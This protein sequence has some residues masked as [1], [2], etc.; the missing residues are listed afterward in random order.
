VENRVGTM[1]LIAGSWRGDGGF[2]ALVAVV[3]TIVGCAE[4]PYLGRFN[5]SA[6][7][8]GN[9]ISIAAGGTFPPDQS[10]TGRA[11]LARRDG[12]GWQV[13]DLGE[14][15]GLTGIAFNGRRWVAVGGEFGNERWGDGSIRE[16]GTVVIS[17]D[18]VTWRE[19][20]TAPPENLLNVVTDGSRFVATAFGSEYVYYSDDGDLWRRIYVGNRLGSEARYA[21]GRFM[22]YGNGPSIME[23]LDGETW[24]E[25]YVG[26]A[27]V[28][29]IR[30]HGNLARGFGASCVQCDPESVQ[31]RALT[32][33]ESG[34]W[35]V[36]A[37][38]GLSSPYDVVFPEGTAVA[39]TF[40]G[41]MFAVDDADGRQWEPIGVFDSSWDSLH[42][43]GSDV[44]LLGFGI[45]VSRDGGR[46]WAL[47]VTDTDGLGGP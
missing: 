23:S 26:V 29:V 3:L 5:Y 4:P 42:A 15:G 39:T 1:N 17:D 47:E 35:V 41:L 45:R 20:L 36:A 33:T 6:M 2:V 9:G 43:G 19:A 27:N 11:A 14:I 16:F 31:P 37:E 38:P 24:T 40:E 34:E 18:G 28:R 25:S 21:A 46:T 10:L 32:L 13:T 8:A 22:A 12:A 7:E 44:F 30:P